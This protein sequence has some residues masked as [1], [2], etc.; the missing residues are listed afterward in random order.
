MKIFLDTANI[1]SI[2]KY[3]DMGLVDGI[4]TNPTLLSKEKGNPAE[5]MREIVKIVKGPVSLEVIGTTVEEKRKEYRQMSRSYF[6]QTKRSLLPKP[7]LP[8]SVH[9][10]V[11]LMIQDT[12][13]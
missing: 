7:V 5:I 6:Q 2:K 12:R 1:E 11:D 8:M 13:A 4:T 3:S 10:L 9:L